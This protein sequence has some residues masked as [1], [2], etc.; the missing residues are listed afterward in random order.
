MNYALILTV[1]TVI[2]IGQLLFKSVGL[3]LGDRGFFALVEDPK[4]AML[5]ATSLVLYGIATFGWIWALRQV[6]LSTAYLFMS[7]GFILVPVMAHYTFGEPI[8]LRF[9]AGTALIISG[10]LLSATA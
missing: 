8:T 6:P 4:T 10:I 1:V 5:F 3:R 2:A 7:L 9:A